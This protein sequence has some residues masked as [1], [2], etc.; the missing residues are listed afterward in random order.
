LTEDKPKKKSGRQFEN[1]RRA[2]EESAKLAQ[3]R[4]DAALLGTVKQRVH[5]AR[6]ERAHLQMLELLTAQA[7]EIRNDAEIIEEHRRDQLCKTAQAMGKI[8]VQAEVQR[9][10]EE[11]EAIVNQRQEELKAERKK[12]LA[13]SKLKLVAQVQRAIERSKTDPAHAEITAAV[14]ALFNSES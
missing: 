8:N 12:L 6:P 2:R 9:E 1:E 4:R 14:S 10:A 13:E 5:P 11:L 3:E 7:C